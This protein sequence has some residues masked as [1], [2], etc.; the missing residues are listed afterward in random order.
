MNTMSFALSGTAPVTQ[1]NNILSLGGRGYPFTVTSSVPWATVSPANGVAPVPLS[2]TIDP[3]TLKPGTYS[4]FLTLSAE[5]T[6]QKITI[7]VTVTAGLP[8]ITAVSNAASGA[9]TIA[10]N[11]FVSIYGSGF[12]PAAATWAPTTILPTTLAGVSVRVN[13]QS[14][15][16]Y[17]ASPTQINV[18][19]PSD[20][21]TG[22]VPVEVTTPA[23]V[24]T[25]S[26]IMAAAAPGWFA[27]SVNS[28]I[29]IAALLGNTAT[30][31]APSGS[32]GGTPSRSAKPGD[33]LVLYANGLGATNPAPP[34]GVVLTTAYQLD[35]YSRVTVTIAGQP[36]PV[37]YAGLVSAGL[38]QVNVQV[39]PNIGIG[40]LPIV[41]IVNGV[42]TQGATLNIQQ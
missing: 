42:P 5:G 24:T 34:T 3:A 10:P 25:A 21:A 28:S 29:Y 22:A 9:P 2:V 17:Y 38:Y 16:I 11:S 33:Y 6:T 41:L 40:D 13:S 35:D 19:L 37:L 7:N 15:Y 23:G 18:L 30:L 26:A 39:P 32:L 8:I 1:T 31:V 36:V 27:Y 20:T 12:A 14:A 4:G